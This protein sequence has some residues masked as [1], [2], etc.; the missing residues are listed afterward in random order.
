[1]E[2]PAAVQEA[3]TELLRHKVSGTTHLKSFT[4]ASGGCINHGGRIT[5]ST[6]T[7]FLKWNDARKFPGMFEAEAKGL[8]L[9]RAP[10]V[11]T[12]PEVLGAGERGSYQFIVMSFVEQQGRSAH[13]W[14]MLGER[15][16]SLHRVTRTSFGL[17]HD[18]YIGS[19][20]QWNKPHAS[21]I[22]FFI[23]QRLQV[24]LELAL[25]DPLLDRAS[26]QKF[27]TLFKQLPGLLP[28]EG[29]SLLHGDLWSGNLI[30][31]EKGEPCLIDPAVYFGHREADL[32]MTQLFGGFD[33]AF[34]DSYNDSF[35]LM[36]GFRERFDLYNLYP[37][38][39]HVNLFGG[40]Y[41]SQVNSI[42]K[43]F[44]G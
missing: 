39:V 29:P 23:E 34:L 28:S 31:D 21:W 26:L 32:A 18:N 15:L 33:D 17:D 16:A 37:L 11:I 2:V 1:M 44:T 27:E 40:S 35:P 41:A 36:P 43:R 20:R 22:D 19:L 10:G 14:H 9:L 30:T 38:L 5:T 24:Q 7:H 42:L 6:G 8:E 3:V 25:K 4:L 12:I 13:Y